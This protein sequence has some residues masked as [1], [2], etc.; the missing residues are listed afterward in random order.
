MGWCSMRTLLMVTSFT[1]M[2][3]FIQYKREVQTYLHNFRAIFAVFTESSDAEAAKIELDLQRKKEQE[4]LMQ[5][6]KE[7]RDNFKKQQL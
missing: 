7:R 6:E 3:G 5:I 4:E 2:V 1:L